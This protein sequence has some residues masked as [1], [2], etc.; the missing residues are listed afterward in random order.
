MSNLN[1]FTAIAT[2]I[3]GA[4]AAGLAFAAIAP[5][6]PF[7]AVLAAAAGFFGTAYAAPKIDAAARKSNHGAPDHRV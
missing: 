2:A 4:A 3:G 5:E 1:N 7:I 6:I